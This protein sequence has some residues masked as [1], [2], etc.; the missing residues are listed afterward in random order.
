[1]ETDTELRW[2]L[3]LCKYASEVGCKVRVFQ[4]VVLT[5]GLICH[6][7]VCILMRVSYPRKSVV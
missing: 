4:L 7:L 3:G 1:M 6:S 5:S 2:N